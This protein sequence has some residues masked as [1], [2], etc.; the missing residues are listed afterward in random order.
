M[1]DGPTVALASIQ[2]SELVITR[3]SAT[4]TGLGQQR[5]PIEVPVVPG[6]ADETRSLGTMIVGAPWGFAAIVTA[7]R[8]FTPPDFPTLPPV[9]GYEVLGF[10]RSGQRITPL[11]A[12]DSVVIPVTLDDPWTVTSVGV[13][14]GLPD[15]QLAIGAHSDI[16][17]AG[18]PLVY[19]TARIRVIELE[20]GHAATEVSNRLFCDG[21]S[22]CHAP[23][24]LVASVGGTRLV[25]AETA[26]NVHDDVPA[27][28]RLARQSVATGALDPSFGQAGRTSQ[29]PG[30]TG[31][32]VRVVDLV[33]SSPDRL[34]VVGAGSTGGVVSRIRDGAG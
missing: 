13:T 5:I 26:D 32:D 30:S 22:T 12:L 1:V 34:F 27:D 24:A 11:S 6:D 29:F 18:L 19:D 10:D 21:R 3:L 31:P 9:A 8:T 17:D 2:G 28:R 7:R 15:H 33:R 14:E 4:G 25:S 16:V 23:D 20:P